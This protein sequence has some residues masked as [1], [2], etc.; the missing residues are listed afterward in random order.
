MGKGFATRDGKVNFEAEVGRKVG[1][2]SVCKMN[3][4]G[5]DDA[6]SEGFLRAVRAK[7]YVSCVW[8]HWHVRERVLERLASR[9]IHPD[10]DPI[11]IPN[12]M[13]KN[14]V[15][16]Y[17]GRAFMRNI[18]EETHTGVHVVVKVLPGGER[19]RI[20]LVDARDESMRVMRTI[21]M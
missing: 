6:M 4:H 3:H 1:P 18:P 17:A 11:V 2:V 20:Y 15:K 21:E 14:R 5:C 13:P 8:S 10:F 19:W 7:A 16:K 9:S 12:F